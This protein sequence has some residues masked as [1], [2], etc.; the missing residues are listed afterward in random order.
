MTPT[1]PRGEPRRQGHKRGPPENPRLIQTSRQHR[2]GDIL[3]EIHPG[4]SRKQ[5]LLSVNG[6]M[7]TW[8]RHTANSSH[9]TG[10]ASVV[11]PRSKNQKE[12]L[13]FWIKAP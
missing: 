7:D 1:P 2:R 9:S 12:N 8:N 13:L 3:R 10:K 4:T 5:L 6:N 11:P